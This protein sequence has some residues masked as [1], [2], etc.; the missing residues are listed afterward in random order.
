MNVQFGMARLLNCDEISNPG[1]F[2]F[3][4]TIST[5]ITIEYRIPVSKTVNV[6]GQGFTAVTGIGA[7]LLSYSI[8]KLL[9]DSTD[10]VISAINAGYDYN[11][12]QGFYFD[13]PLGICYITPYN[14]RHHNFSFELT[15]RTGFLVCSRSY[16]KM[17][18]GGEKKEIV[19]K[20]TGLLNRFH[21][22]FN[23]K[24]SWNVMYLEPNKNELTGFRFS[25]WGEYYP[26][27]VFPSGKGVSAQTSAAGVGIGFN[28]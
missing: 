26:T 21:T 10:I 2:K 3:S 13:I 12:L 16:I 17:N 6:E 19:E 28:F 18:I 22:G 8:D 27:N 15:S 4:K 23:A 24:V 20:N 1:K 5:G 25:L 7:N 14:D 11:A 9:R